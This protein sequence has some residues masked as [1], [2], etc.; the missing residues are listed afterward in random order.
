MQDYEQVLDPRTGLP[1][2]L[3]IETNLI[4]C[5]YYSN[6]SKSCVFVTEQVDMRPLE[7]KLWPIRHSP[8]FHTELTGYDYPVYT[9]MKI[10]VAN[11]NTLDISEA[12]QKEIF[13]EVAKIYVSMPEHVANMKSYALAYKKDLA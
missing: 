9:G 1:V 12:K 6:D 10:K 4:G 3:A 7:C 2:A 11:G 5:G 8:E 13:R